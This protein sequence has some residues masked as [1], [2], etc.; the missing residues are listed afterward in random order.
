MAYLRDKGEPL[1]EH[2]RQLIQRHADAG[3]T[4]CSTI[5]ELADL[6]EIIAAHHERF[7]GSGYGRGLRG[8]EIPIEARIIAVAD[9]F[10]AMTSAREYRKTKDVF[11]AIQSIEESANTLFDPSVVAAFLAALGQRT[12]RAAG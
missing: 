1:T 11:S 4:F 2:E 10:L 12:Y 9:S 6:A 8:A 3:A 7:D 5:P